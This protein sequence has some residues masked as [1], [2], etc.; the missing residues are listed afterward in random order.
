MMQDVVKVSLIRLAVN[1]IIVAIILTAGHSLI[2]SEQLKTGVLLYAVLPPQYITPIFIRDAKE[3]AFAATT[4]SFHTLI[5]IAGYI[6]L[7]AIAA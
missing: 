1:S 2:I 3:S 7:A 6:I 5:T 4:L